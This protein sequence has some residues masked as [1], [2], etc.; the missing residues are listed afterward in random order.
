VRLSLRGDAHVNGA[1]GCD[2]RFRRFVEVSKGNLGQYCNAAT[3]YA[4]SYAVALRLGVALLAA[5]VAVSALFEDCLRLT[6][7]HKLYNS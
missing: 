4:N 6:S 7:K 2:R 5:L 1:E 3:V